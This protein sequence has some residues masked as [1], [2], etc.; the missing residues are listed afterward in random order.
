MYSV[1]CEDQPS[2]KGAEGRIESYLVTAL[3]TLSSLSLD[4][5][6]HPLHHTQD[7]RRDP[8]C[9]YG[10]GGAYNMYEERANE[11]RRLWV[12]VRAV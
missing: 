3:R 11:Y 2:P 10:P 4:I 6:L 9:G 12:K 7:A 8:L 5:S 1:W